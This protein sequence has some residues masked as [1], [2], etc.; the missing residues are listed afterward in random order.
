MTGSPYLF[1]RL[2]VSHHSRFQFGFSP[3][4]RSPLRPVFR[5]RGHAA[6]CSCLALWCCFFFLPFWRGPYKWRGVGCLTDSRAYR[7]ALYCGM[8]DKWGMLKVVFSLVNTLT[9]WL[10][11]TSMNGHMIFHKGLFPPQSH[12]L[13]SQSLST[14][15][16]GQN[17]TSAL[18]LFIAF[19]RQEHVCQG[20]R[21]P[22]LAPSNAIRTQPRDKTSC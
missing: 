3:Q 8:T 22:E 1:P 15:L 10:V 20:T 9:F 13:L 4:P 2:S 18:C 7:A 12:Q 11:G 19:V 14:G 6:T 16:C 21:Y 17:V 5:G